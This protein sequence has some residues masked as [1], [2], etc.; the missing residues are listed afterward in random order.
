MGGGGGGVSRGQSKVLNAKA[1]TVGI[2]VNDRKPLAIKRFGPIAG[3]RR[4]VWAPS[5]QDG[6]LP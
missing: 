2:N 3:G 5:V 4:A 6:V 1:T